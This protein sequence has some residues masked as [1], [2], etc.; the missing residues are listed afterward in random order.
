MT[1]PMSLPDAAK[2][3]SVKAS[4]PP[5]STSN[6]N[7]APFAAPVNVPPRK[8]RAPSEFTKAKPLIPGLLIVF[9]LKLNTASGSITSVILIPFPV[10]VSMLLFVKLN[11]PPVPTMALD[12]LSNAMP[13]PMPSVLT[14]G[15]TFVNVLLVKFHMFSALKVS[16][17]IP[18]SPISSNVLS[19]NVR[20]FPRDVTL[21][22]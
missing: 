1:T 3:V 11:V 4:E 7:P 10:T 2:L 20:V 19:E 6:K 12:P 5:P 16:I 22:I 21:L 18:D 13:S 15:P 8:S 14:I 9:S 17:R